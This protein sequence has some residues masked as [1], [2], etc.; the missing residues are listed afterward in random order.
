[1]KDM[2]VK[3]N[4][5]IEAK[6]KLSI[7]EQR[8]IYSLCSKINKNDED[9]KAYRYNLQEIQQILN[10]KYSMK[11]VKQIIEGLR[12]RKLAIKKELSVLHI[13]WLSSAEYF[14]DYRIEL[15]F[16]P[17]LKPYLL[18]LKDCFTKMLL[19]EVSKFTNVNTSRIYELCSQYL[20][21]GKR[22]ITIEELRY[23]L[24]LEEDEYLLYADFKKRII[25]PAIKEINE[26]TR[27]NVSFT[28]IKTGRKVTGLNFEITGEEIKSPA[29]KETYFKP[30]NENK[31]STFNN[32]EQREY[33]F[34][35]LEKRLL[36]WK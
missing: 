28:E 18:Q 15:C 36:G 11:E 6:Y 30:K 2:I 24:Q 14:D 21:I 20:K 3:S 10:K 33:D 32:F 22:N 12:D 16:D 26:K 19:E 5:M 23:Y 17:K 25:N 35:D 29:L 13:N 27:L 8:L 34:D 9:F 31:K 1:M 4:Y 7:P